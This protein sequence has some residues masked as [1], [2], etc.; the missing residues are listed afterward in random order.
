MRF[1]RALQQCPLACCVSTNGA[2][3]GRPASAERWLKLGARRKKALVALATSHPSGIQ[4]SA[5]HL[6]AP[7]ESRSDNRVTLMLVSVTVLREPDLLVAAR[8]FPAESLK[9]LSSGCA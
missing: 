2:L 3:H 8:W 1:S 6:G 4:C 5:R 9:G 7:L